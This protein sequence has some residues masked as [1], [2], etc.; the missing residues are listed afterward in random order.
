LSGFLDA[1]GREIVLKS[2]RLGRVLDAAG[3][4]L[5]DFRIF[6]SVRSVTTRGG[7][8]SKARRCAVCG[9]II[10]APVKSYHL[11]GDASTFMRLIGTNLSSSLIADESIVERIDRKRFKNLGIS[12]IRLFAAPL[13]GYP[14][15][16]EE[17]PALA[18]QSNQSIR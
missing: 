16:L 13:D 15:N 11:V 12:K 1:I 3:K 9:S 5:A 8:T 14:V 2:L 10:Y 7:P 18:T 4:P 6:Q 17:A